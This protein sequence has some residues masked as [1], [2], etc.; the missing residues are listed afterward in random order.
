MTL[1]Q[2]QK[3]RADTI[4]STINNEEM[5]LCVSN[6]IW[7]RDAGT[8]QASHHTNTSQSRFSKLINKNLKHQLI[9][10]SNNELILR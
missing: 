9:I 6:A 10:T 5:S 2:T 1:S 3:R 4:G 8:A 7:G